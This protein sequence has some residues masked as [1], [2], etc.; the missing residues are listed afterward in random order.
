MTASK[1]AK[2]EENLEHL[3][4]KLGHL[5]QLA[6]TLSRGKYMWESTFDAIGD[7]VMI[8]DEDFQILRA[9]LAAAN[10][11]NQDIRAMIHRKCYE[12]FAGR[13]D[14]CPLC[15]LAT[16]LKRNEPGT[17]WVDQLMKSRDFQ[18]S[19][20]PYEDPIS[21]KKAVVHHY[22]EVTDEKRLQR[23][24][25]QSEKM[26]ALGMLAGGVAHEIN[27]PLGGILA[28]AQLIMRDLETDNPLRDDVQ[29]IESAALRCKEIV[30]NL[31]EFSRQSGDTESKE[32]DINNTVEKLLPLIR[33]RLRSQKIE[34][35]TIYDEK[36]PRVMGSG[37]R[38]QQVI[39][40]LLTNAAQAIGREGSI[41]LVTE[42]DD[43][44]G[45][46]MITVED[47][48][49]G[50]S[51]A[52]LGRIFDPFFTTKEAGDGT[53]LGLSICYSIISEHHGQI[54]VQSEVG[55]GTVFK[56]SLPL[57]SEE[58]PAS[59]SDTVGGAG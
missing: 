19:S 39:L 9:N 23:K 38:L 16:T 31:L 40:N 30:E 8:I 1:P 5:E 12:V 45:L 41:K 27:N 59:K 35:K 14:V 48:G 55:K 36:Q 37:T 44:S 58:M 13:D 4:D 53:G 52:D 51:S 43:D 32:V 7:P 10:Q 21:G 17:I 15:P 28:F 25:V 57:L 3:L 34:L 56:I 46:V 49:P 22:R 29:E 26:A 42:V 54:D 20:Y 24:L 2:K 47:T 33:L 18:V 6:E 50:I 11:S